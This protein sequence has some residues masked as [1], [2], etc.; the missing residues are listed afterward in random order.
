[1][2]AVYYTNTLN[3]IFIV[4]ANWNESV[5]RYVTPLVNI[6][7]IPSQQVFALTP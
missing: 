4:L 5:R 3:R 2:S 1:M 7:L 6:I